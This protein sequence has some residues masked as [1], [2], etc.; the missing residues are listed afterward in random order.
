MACLMLRPRALP[1]GGGTAFPTW[2]KVEKPNQSARLSISYTLCCQRH[3]RRVAL[4]L[5]ITCCRTPK[6]SSQENKE[7]GCP[8]ISFR[9]CL[10]LAVSNSTRSWTNKGLGFDLKLQPHMLFI[11]IRL[12]HQQWLKEP[13]RL[14][15]A[16]VGFL[17]FIR[18]L[19]LP[20]IVLL[21]L[22]W[23]RPQKGRE[24]REKKGETGP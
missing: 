19:K 1:S 11:K 5:K 14:S 15:R 20:A 3:K 7:Y 16:Q 2:S 24:S 4:F 18:S 22:D 10:F 6:A 23:A 12:L 21:R 9:P 8:A 13:P 17:S